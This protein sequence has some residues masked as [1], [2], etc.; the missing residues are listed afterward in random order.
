M[1]VYTDICHVVHHYNLKS[2]ASV[3]EEEIGEE[4]QIEE[5][6]EA[7]EQKKKDVRNAKACEKR[8]AQKH[9]QAWA[10]VVLPQRGLKAASQTSRAI[11]KPSQAAVM[12]L[13]YNGLALA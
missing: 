3:H 13:A 12:A 7:A 1:W 6:P 4:V 5:D 8:P 10:D 2:S 11:L 9:A